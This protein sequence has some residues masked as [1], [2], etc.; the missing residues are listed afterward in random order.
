MP[1]TYSTTDF[2]LSDLI[3]RLYTVESTVVHI[4]GKALLRH[5]EMAELIS[6]ILVLKIDLNTKRAL[7]NRNDRSAAPKKPEKGAFQK[8]K[9]KNDLGI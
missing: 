8:I 7:N 6:Q 1:V 3:N 2:E 4:C 9:E 5:L